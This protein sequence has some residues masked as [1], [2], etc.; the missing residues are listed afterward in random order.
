M[1]TQSPGA[2]RVGIGGWT[3]APWRGSFY[4]PG[5]PHARELWHASRQLTAIEINGTFYS[6]QK[7]AIFAKWREQ[8]PEGFVFSVKASQY[9]THRR[10]LAEAGESV[11]R[12]VNGGVVELGDKLGPIVWQFM[13]TKVFDPV[14]FEAFLR[15]LPPKAGGVALRH[16]VDVRHLSFRDPAFIKMLKKHRVAAVLTDEPDLPWI[17]DLTSDLV[18]LRL[19]ASRADLPQGYPPVDLDALAGCAAAWSA[20][21]EPTGV[22][23]VLP[24]APRRQPREVFVYFIN[25]A[26]ERAP[27]AAQALISRLG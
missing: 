24:G 4:P 19:M 17:A 1:A 21:G 23:K 18:Y 8:V 10:V 13:R 9:A 2:M 26:K 27:A 16:V 12:F 3:F 6:A 25:G 5:L 14:D 15:L 22:P 11:E 7:P 20:G